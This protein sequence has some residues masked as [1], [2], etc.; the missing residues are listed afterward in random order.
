MS[1]V[2]VGPEFYQIMQ[3]G[4]PWT[5]EAEG[6]QDAPV[7]GW[8]VNPALVGPAQ[9]AV[10]EVATSDVLPVLVC[11]ALVVGVLAVA[12]L[13]GIGFTPNRRR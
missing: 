11:G 5:Q 6:W 1:Y 13:S 9:Q 4:T 12:S 7:P 2:S 8:G 10:G 3:P